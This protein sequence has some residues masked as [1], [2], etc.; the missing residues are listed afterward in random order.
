MAELVRY[1]QCS[2]DD[3]IVTMNGPNKNALEWMGRKVNYCPWCGTHILYEEP[4]LTNDELRFL[5][6]MVIKPSKPA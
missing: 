3:W 6:D 1:N 5:R 4:S 2:C